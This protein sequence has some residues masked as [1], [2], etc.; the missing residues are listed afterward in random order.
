MRARGTEVETTK[1]FLLRCHFLQ[2]SNLE[3][4]DPNLLGLSG[5]NQVYFS[6]YGS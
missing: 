1:H 2:Y 5:K 6:L 3:K 4:F